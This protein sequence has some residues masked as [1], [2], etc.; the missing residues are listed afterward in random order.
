MSMSN[1]ELFVILYVIVLLHNYKIQNKS[2]ICQMYILNK[3]PSMQLA[4]SPNLSFIVLF[5]IQHGPRMLYAGP[6]ALE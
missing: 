5:N 1:V 2:I 3:D 6:M 4:Q